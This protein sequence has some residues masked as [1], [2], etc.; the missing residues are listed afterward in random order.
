MLNKISCAFLF[1]ASCLTAA[2]SPAVFRVDDHVYRGRQPQQADYALL[3]QMGIRTVLDLRG[4]SIH[5]PRER[6]EVEASGM[7]YVSIQLSGLFAPSYKQ[8]SR[9]L[10][11]LEDPERGPVFVHCRRGDDRSGV[12]IACYRMAHDHWTNKQ[13]MAEALEHGISSFEVLMRRFIRLFDPS[14]FHPP[15]VY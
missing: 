6:K 11:V 13:A 12:V 4:G 8:V 7:S 5:A 10:A 1:T 14:R 15:D 2:G 9:I 3:A